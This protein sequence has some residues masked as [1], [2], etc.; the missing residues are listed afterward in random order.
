MS[1]AIVPDRLLYNETRQLEALVELQR[2][3]PRRIERLGQAK[4]V[5]DG[6]DVLRIASR[7]VACC[8]IGFPGATMPSGIV[9]D[10]KRNM[11]MILRWIMH[12]SLRIC[13]F[14][15]LLAGR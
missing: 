7:L 8:S 2:L 14:E 6:L 9:S 5:D 3:E 11:A 13:S 4:R 12:N 10:L 1:A 15:D